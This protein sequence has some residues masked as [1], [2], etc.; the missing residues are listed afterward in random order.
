M[1]AETDVHGEVTVSEVEEKRSYQD[2]HKDNNGVIINGN[3]NGNEKNCNKEDADGSYVFVTGADAVSGDHVEPSDLGGEVI[4]E[5]VGLENSETAGGGV[6]GELKPESNGGGVSEKVEN[7]TEDV[8]ESEPSGEAEAEAEINERTEVKVEESSEDVGGAEEEVEAEIDERIEVKVEESSEEVRDAETEAKA[9]I[10][11]RIEVKVEEYSEDVRG[12]EAEAEIDE[13]IEVKVEESSED[14]RGIEDSQV[15]VSISEAV[16]CECESTQVDDGKAVDGEDNNLELTG[17][18]EIIEESQVSVNNSA[19]SEPAIELDDGVKNVV[20]EREYDLVT[21]GKENEESKNMARLNGQTD[22]DP[23]KER[24]ELTD[25]VPVEGALEGP[26][27]ELEQ[28]QRTV[29]TDTELETEIGNGPVP[30]DDGDGLPANHTADEPTETIDAEQNG[31]SENCEILSFPIVCGDDDVKEIPVEADTEEHEVDSEQNSEKASCQLANKLLEPEV[32]NGPVPDESGDCLAIEHDQDSISENLVNNDMVGATQNTPEQNGS[33]KEVECLPSPVVFGKVPVENGESFPTAPDND[34][35]VEVDAENE[36]SPI[37]EKIPTCVAEDD[38]P[39]AEVGNLDANRSISPDDT[40][41]EINTETSPD[42]IIKAENGPDSCSADNTKLEI[43]TETSPDETVKAENGPDSCPADDTKSEIKAETSTDETVKAENG[44]DSC[45][46]DDTKLEINTKVSP[47]ETI[48]A[49]NGSDACPADDT[50]SEIK[51]ETS[52][53]D[54]IK[55]ENGPNSCPADDTKSEIN[56]ETIPDE[57]IKAENGPDYSILSSHDNNVRSETETGSVV[58]DSEEKISDQPSDDT[59][60][61]SGV[62][63]MVVACADDQHHSISATVVESNING[64]VENE[65]GFSTSLG[66]DEKSESEVENT[67]TLTNRDMPCDD[68]LGSESKVL[69]GSATVSETALNCVPDVVHAEDGDDR[70]TST[71]SGDKPATQGAEGMSGIHGDETSI[72]SPEGPTVDA[73]EGLNTEVV[74]RPFYY[75]IRVPR[76]D[77][78]NLKEQVKR[79][80]LQVEEKTRSRDAIRAEIQMKRVTW[81]EH[82]ENFDAAMAEERTARELLRSKRQEMDSVQSMINKVKNAISVEDIGGRIR[83]MEHAMQHETLDLK[84]EKK[85]LHEMRQLKQLREQL[86]S[87]MGRQDDVQQALDQKDQIEE[88]MKVLRKELDV[89]RENVLKAEAVTKAAKKKFNDESDKISELQAQFKA[90]DDIR[91]E[92]YAHLQ[93]IKKQA[94]EKNKYFY[95]YRDDN[96]LAAN[97]VT[98]GEKEELQ[99]LCV[100]QVEKIM[101]LWNKNDEFRKEYI[102][103]NTRSTLRRLRTLDGRSLGPNEEPPLIPTVAYERV[104]KDNSRVTKD[105][106]V[107]LLS[108]VEQEKPVKQEKQVVQVETEKVKEKSIVKTAEQKN[109]TTKSKM[110][111]KPDL[112]GNGLATVSGRDEIEEAKEEESKLTK[113]EEELARKAEELRREKEAAKLKE[114]RKLEEKNKAKEALERK[115]RN[116]EKAQARAMLRAQKEAEQKEKEREKKARKKEKKKASGEEATDG[117]VELEIAQSLETPTETTKESETREK[118]MTVTKRSQKPLQFTKPAKAKSIPPPLRNRGKRRMQ[119]WMWVLVA[120][121]VVFALFL[122]GNSSFSFNFGLQRFGF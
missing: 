50:K 114:Q 67:S 96:N 8:G 101:E 18:V 19:E 115:K 113:E 71:D 55:A 105:N 75:L 81:K 117:A 94:Y 9:E 92:A 15:M 116:A 86:S 61:E 46:A 65:S 83:N 84:E 24:P 62:S 43:D 68:G 70:L 98:K 95:S 99:R 2:L 23:E 34:T 32:V 51:V 102:R 17:E 26:G 106:S 41:L 39:E 108:A 100:N 72:T 31:S 59:K 54:T 76:Y 110:P 45:P 66:A 112:L 79:A 89:L 56:I 21:D 52:T 60:I 7:V 93:S 109:Q 5:N 88:R 80:Q 13:R 120:A 3:G 122:V 11:E 10:D 4:V 58:I 6:G 47:D 104:T 25:D 82:G 103:C 64:L 73:L 28:K 12:A 111:V 1:T 44:P 36:A 48:K 91:Q 74:K 85:Y 57:T 42:E 87:N 69:D 20:E 22:L 77:D 16:D 78:E 27:V 63:E 14:V 40:E 37:T 90:A 118:P 53:D 33:S 97:L 30:V 121:M 107:S 38:M 35:A 119:T 49:E 29:V